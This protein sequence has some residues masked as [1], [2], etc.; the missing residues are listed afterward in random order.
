LATLAPTFELI[1]AARLLQGCG[2]GAAPVITLAALTRIYPSA[3]VPK[4]L[5]TW[6]ASSVVLTAAGPVLG[7]LSTS[8]L[9]WQAAV[10]VPTLSA[11]A[12]LLVRR[13][14][15]AGGTAGTLDFTGALWV[16]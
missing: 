3:R 11:V 6:T 12:L 13:H 9:G 10:L 14:L 16:V 15:P 7:G 5:A 2:A 4:A 1:V 8:V